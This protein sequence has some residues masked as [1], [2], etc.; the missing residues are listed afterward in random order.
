TTN[1]KLLFERLNK[2]VINTWISTPSFVDI[3]LLDPSFTEK[4]HPQLVQFILCGE[5]LTKKTAEKLLTAFP[6]AN[7]Y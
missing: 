2:T 5:E 4:E 7:I 1:F 6:S 3:C